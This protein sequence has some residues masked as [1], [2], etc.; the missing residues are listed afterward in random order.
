LAIPSRPQAVAIVV[1]AALALVCVAELNHR[2]LERPFRAR[3]RQIA[4]DFQARRL[5]ATL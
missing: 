5:M 3:G 1:L 4:A 2:L